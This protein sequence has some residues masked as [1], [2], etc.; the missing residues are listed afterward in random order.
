MSIKQKINKNLPIENRAALIQER[1]TDDYLNTEVKDYASYVVKNRALPNIM[2]GLR[3]GARKI[4]WAAINGKIKSG[5]K[6]KLSVLLGNTMEYEYHHG[7]VALKNTCEQL[8]AKHLF[9]FAPLDVIGQTGTLRVPEVNTAARY[10]SVQINNN[11]ENFKVDKE[12]LQLIQDEGK[13]IE[14]TFLLPI[15]PVVLLWRTNSPGFGFSFRSFSHDINDI[16]DASIS[17]I[18]TGSCDDINYYPIKPFIQGIKDSNIIYNESK[19]SWYNVGE[20]SENLERDT[21]LITDLPF[22]VNYSKYEQHLKD[23]KEVGFIT[24]YINNSSKGK[25]NILLMFRKGML[26]K[27]MSEKWTFFAKLKLYTKV[28]K[29]TLNCI[30]YDCNSII[31]F[32]SP[33]ALIDGFVK[34]RKIFYARRKTFLVKTIEQTI[35]DLSDKAKFIKLVI[36]GNLIIFKRKIEDVKK[37][38]DKLGVSYNGLKLQTI[39]FTEEEITKALQE[40]GELKVQLDYI[41]NSTIEEMYINDLIELKTKVSKINKISK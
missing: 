14:P 37:D 6:E 26:S 5:K 39:R 13:E 31:N 1:E 17:S 7:D 35:E 24:K 3:V 9:E 15:V 23:L 18:I 38:C 33:Q 41:K 20:Y 21:I 11:I 10:L 27:L 2:D 36:D 32:E 16:I 28:P 12:L 40:I 29:L 34:R 22:N 19:N 30:D 8:G 25:I 4:L